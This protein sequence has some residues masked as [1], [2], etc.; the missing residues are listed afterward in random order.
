MTVTHSSFQTLPF[1]D[2]ATLV[3][4][5]FADIGHA[6]R[7]LEKYKNDVTADRGRARQRAK[8]T[9][10]STKTSELIPA[11]I[12]ADY[13]RFFAYVIMERAFLAHLKALDAVRTVNAME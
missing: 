12:L 13:P 8:I 10:I 2:Q 7:D 6:V 3:L 4:A 11:T 9:G 1:G 5:H